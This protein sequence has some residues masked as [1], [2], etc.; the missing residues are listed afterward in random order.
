MSCLLWM[1]PVLFMVHELEEIIKVVKVMP[2]SDYL[3]RYSFTIAVL[4]ELLIILGVSLYAQLSDNYLIWLG[5]FIAVVIH[6]IPHIGI[7]IKLKAYIP[8]VTTSF[9]LLPICSYIIW[10]MLMNANYNWLQVASVTLICGVLFLINLLWLHKM[11]PTFEKWVHAS[12]THPLKGI[13]VTLYLFVTRK[14]K[15]QKER[16]GEKLIDDDGKVFTVF[17]H[18]VIK[19]YK[20][21]KPKARFVIRFTL[22]DMS[23]EDNIKFSRLPMMV[24]MGFT[25]FASK[26]WTVN[27]GTGEFQGIYMWDSY[28][29]AVNY[30]QSI[31]V[32]FMT[33]R[34]KPGSVTFYIEDCSNS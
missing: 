1:F 14:V 33:K 29:D 3:S 27:N 18:V 9:I 17:R 11:M 15:F 26:Y 5:L 12:K 7:A 21:H 28:E 13:L 10:K 30:S 23:I 16:I 20:E 25:G 32:D 24:F 4:E 34:S 2:Y 31:A 19:K 22:E 8:G 6:F